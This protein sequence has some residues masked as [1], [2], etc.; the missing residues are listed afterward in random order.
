MSA[1]AIAV[2]LTSSVSRGAAVPMPTLAPLTKSGES[3][4][5]LAPENSGTYPATP[6]VV[7]T[8]VAVSGVMAGVMAGEI[9]A[10][11]VRDPASANA[12]AGKPPRVAASAALS[13]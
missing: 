3:T 4:M 13:A 9:A 7:V 1:D 11:E 2:P 12:E 5:L 6:P 8:L 10:A